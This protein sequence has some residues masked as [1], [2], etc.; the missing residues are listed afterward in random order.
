GD[1][2]ALGDRGQPR[3]VDERARTRGSRARSGGGIMNSPVEDQLRRALA[4]A[5][6]TVRV[7]TIAPL[8]PAQRRRQVPVRALVAAVVTVA[9]AVIVLPR[10]HGGGETAVAA[11]PPRDKADLT[12]F[13]CRKTA[14]PAC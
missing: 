3:P 1:S 8:R 13:L 4:E 10:L 14:G 6:E 11:A 7:E 9:L 2:R 5:A 12:V